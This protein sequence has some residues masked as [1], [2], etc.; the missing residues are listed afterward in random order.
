MKTRFLIVAAVALLACAY[1]I[2][3]LPY[4]G[5]TQ[6]RFDCIQDG[7]T[8]AEVEELLGDP[9]V[10]YGPTSIRV[11]F[12]FPPKLPPRSTSTIWNGHEGAAVIHFNENS[13]MTFKGWYPNPA[14]RTV[15]EKVWRWLME[16]F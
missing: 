2:L 3:A 8:M 1:V 10:N 11:L 14:R 13:V 6:A 5:V 4:S 9:S 16:R 12:P 15:Y 7:V